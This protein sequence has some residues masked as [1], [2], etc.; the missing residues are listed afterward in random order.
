MQQQIPQHLRQQMQQLGQQPPFQQL[1]QQ[2]G[3]QQ[4]PQDQAPQISTQ[5]I[6]GN[7]SESFWDVVQPLPGQ[8]SLLYLHVDGDWRVYVNPSE[9]TRDQVQEA[10]TYGL[11]VIGYYDTNNPGLLL[12]VVITR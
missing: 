4:V 11:P 3:Q 5:A 8:A 1:L 2:L 12:A 9:R 10:F 6:A 7:V